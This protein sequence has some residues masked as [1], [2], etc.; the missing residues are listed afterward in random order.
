MYSR[1]RGGGGVG[2]PRHYVRVRGTFLREDQ[3]T[4][5]FEGT[6]KPKTHAEGSTL[7]LLWLSES[8]EGYLRGFRVPLHDSVLDQFDQRGDIVKLSLLQDTLDQEESQ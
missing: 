8:P 3:S 2:G 6:Y 4:T 1:A 5:F 7:T